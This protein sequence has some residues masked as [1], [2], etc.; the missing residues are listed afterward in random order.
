MSLLEETLL[1]TSCSAAVLLHPF[2]NK[3]HERLITCSQNK[4]K[5]ASGGNDL[6]TR[7]G[8]AVQGEKETRLSFIPK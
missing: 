1:C 2:L 3:C 7:K 8:D 4:S 6:I 5:A